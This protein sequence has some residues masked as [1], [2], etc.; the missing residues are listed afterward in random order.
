MGGLQVTLGPGSYLDL[1]G[2]L[3]TNSVKY[4][5]QF[6]KHISYKDLDNE[7]VEVD[8]VGDKKSMKLDVD[9]IL[10]MANVTVLF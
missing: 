7:P 9:K 8:D 10:L 2:G 3:M 6:K 5:Q 4:T 1:Q